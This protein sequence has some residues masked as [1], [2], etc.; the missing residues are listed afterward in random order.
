MLADAHLLSARDGVDAGQVANKGLEIVS[1]L[2]LFVLL[3]GQDICILLSVGRHR[4][5]LLGYLGA[6]EDGEGCMVACVLGLRAS[7]L[8]ETDQMVIQSQHIGY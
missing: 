4:S 1:S 6:V 3:D 8:A 2:F 7:P 5:L